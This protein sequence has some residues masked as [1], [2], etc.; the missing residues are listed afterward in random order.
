MK[1]IVRFFRRT[2]PVSLTLI[3]PLLISPSLAQITQGDPVMERFDIDSFNHHQSGGNWLRELP[4]GT[5]I[6]QWENSGYGYQVEIT[7]PHSAYTNVKLFSYDGR[8]IWTTQRFFGIHFGSSKEYNSNGSVIRELDKDTGFAFSVDDLIRK[9]QTDYKVD[10]TD[11]RQ[12]FK[13]IRG[14]DNF[15]GQKTPFYGVYVYDFS[16]DDGRGTTQTLAYLFHG[17]TGK[18][19]YTIPADIE[20]CP[21]IVLEYTRF[22][23]QRQTGK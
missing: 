4:D 11:T 9:M 19:L 23:E 5:K 7:P 20:G 12:A 17:S 16:Q 15:A 8:L 14:I 13:V 3:F 10:I 1:P 6:F 18:L 22:V 2:L 21:S